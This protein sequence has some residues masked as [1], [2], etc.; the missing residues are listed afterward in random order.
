MS[1]MCFKCDREESKDVPFPKE[2]NQCKKCD[3]A[4]KAEWYQAKKAGHPPKSC[5]DCGKSLPSR[6]HRYCIECK[7]MRSMALARRKA[8]QYA[9]SKRQH[10]D[11]DV[12]TVSQKLVWPMKEENV[13]SKQK[14]VHPNQNR[15]RMRLIQRARRICEDCGVLLPVETIDAP[16]LKY[17]ES[18]IGK[19]KRESSRLR[20]FDLYHRRKNGV[21]ELGKSLVEFAC[22][23]CDTTFQHPIGVRGPRV[24]QFCDACVDNHRA[25]TQENRKEKKREKDRL[26]M[27][28]KRKHGFKRND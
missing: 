11:E 17:C 4:R 18:C 8:Q 13:L 16:R 19:R 23:D 15:D 1:R 14:Q 10:I 7:E 2:G 24:K 6:Y 28:E 22:K 5:L 12:Q 26:R 27:Q 25:Q 3:A 21:S 20:A 9:R